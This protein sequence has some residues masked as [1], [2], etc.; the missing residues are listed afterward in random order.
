MIYDKKYLE[1]DLGFRLPNDSMHQDTEIFQVGFHACHK[2][3]LDDEWDSTLQGI[4][5]FHSLQ[6][7]LYQGRIIE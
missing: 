4:F 3:Q 7:S 1:F 6:L 2:S 5:D